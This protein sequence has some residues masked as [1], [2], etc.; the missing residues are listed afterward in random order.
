MLFKFEIEW[1]E[2]VQHALQAPCGVIGTAVTFLLVFRVNTGY[3]RWWEGRKCFREVV[4]HSRD[5]ARQAA[6]F[7]NDYYLAEKFLRWLVV[8]VY[9]LRQHIREEDWVD[10]VRGILNDDGVNYLDSCRNK[11]FA[12]SLRLS[13]LMHE[14]VASRALLPDLAPAFD[15]NISDLVNSIGTCEMCVTPSPSPHRAPAQQTFCSE[16]K[17]ILLVMA[18]ALCQLLVWVSVRECARTAA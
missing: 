4:N 16:Q 17:M 2:R 14:A 5:L 11:A 1:Q 7:I 9:M 15:L 12:S 6:T 18:N 3:E 10:E 8:S 13:E